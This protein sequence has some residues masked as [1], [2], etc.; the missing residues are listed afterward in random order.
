MST[1]ILENET[2]TVGKVSRSAIRAYRES[3]ARGECDETIL[4]N[5][6]K[7]KIE[8]DKDRTVYLSRVGAHESLTTEIPR[9]K[10]VAAEVSKRL[11]DAQTFAT[12]PL[13]D[14]LTIGEL[15]ERISVANEKV[16]TGTPAEL[17]AALQWLGDTM[18]GGHLGACKS[19]SDCCPW[20]C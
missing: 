5:G 18:P 13:A 12:S 1:A 9:L 19:Q 14:N 10:E 3:V 11:T 4:F 15:R 7:L 8:W 17:A 2:A 20:G 6:R 16:S